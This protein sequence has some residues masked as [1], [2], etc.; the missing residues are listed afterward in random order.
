[1]VVVKPIQLYRVAISPFLPTSCRYHP[2]CSQYAIEAI[3]RHGV[4]KGVGLAIRR[5]LRCSPL[6]GWGEDPVPR[7]S[8][9]VPE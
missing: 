1:M 7:T 9:R 5:M 4:V 6:G 2:S 3:E 8:R